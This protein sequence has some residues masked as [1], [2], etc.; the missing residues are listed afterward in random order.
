MA[1]NSVKHIEIRQYGPVKGAGVVQRSQRGGFEEGECS[2]RI[3]EIHVVVHDVHEPR[4][5]TLN[6]KL[7]HNVEAEQ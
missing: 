7:R 2:M 1:G 3:P 4:G 6:S 5:P